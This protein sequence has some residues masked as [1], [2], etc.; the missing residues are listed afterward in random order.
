[1]HFSYRGFEQVNGI[2]QF[3]FAGIVEKQPQFLFSFA[4]D[5]KVLME[6]RVSIQE[7]P[8]LC[9]QVLMRCAKDG[10]AQI[11]PSVVYQ[12]SPDDL[13]GFTAPR[14]ALALAHQNKKPM[15][16]NRPKPSQASQV[17]GSPATAFQA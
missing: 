2:R 6:Y 13:L 4:V 9:L 15:R 1:M 8:A 16:V 7:A 5:L 14:R 10:V 17:F 12:I 3:K 11:D